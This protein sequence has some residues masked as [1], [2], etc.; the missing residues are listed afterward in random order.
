MHPT[1]DAG[2]HRLDEI[3][4]RLRL[5]IFGERERGREREREREREGERESEREI[6]EHSK[7]IRVRTMDLHCECQVFDH[8][9]ANTKSGSYLD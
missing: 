5:S 3:A 1:H 6:R 8:R 9:Q 2:L 7:L 4:D